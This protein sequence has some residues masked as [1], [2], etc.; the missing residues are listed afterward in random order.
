MI[1]V[2][3]TWLPP[4]ASEERPLVIWG[5]SGH[6]LVV[7]DIV[8]LQKVYQIVG[9]LDDVDPDRRGHKFC[10][11]PILGGREQLSLLLEQGIKHILLGFGHCGM[12]LELTMLP[13]YLGFTLPA[14]HPVS[15]LFDH[16]S[17]IVSQEHV[18]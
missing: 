8:R 17:Y 18:L 13:K 1:N 3:K 6:A 12:R 7:A 2:T 11:A 5:A 9:F 14:A 10:G 15:R 4:Q 16:H